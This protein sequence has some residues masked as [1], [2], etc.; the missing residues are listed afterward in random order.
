MSYSFGP[1]QSA[2]VKV[3]LSGGPPD[4]STAITFRIDDPTRG[5]FDVW[6][7]EEQ[8]RSG[9]TVEISYS[10]EDSTYNL[11]DREYIISVYA[12]GDELIGVWEG[13]FGQ[14]E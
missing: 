12:D 14:E 13:K 2:Y 6:S 7:D 9:D 11:F 4:A 3:T 1:M 10:E 8:Y 5:E